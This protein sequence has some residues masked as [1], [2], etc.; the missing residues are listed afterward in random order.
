MIVFIDAEFTD[1]L[2]PQLLSLGAVTLDG[3][4]HYIELD[5][6]SD[7]GQERLEVSSDFVRND[8][9]L[10][11]FGL[12][13]DASCTYGDMG[14]RTGEWLLQLASE[15]GTRVE[16]AFDYSTDYQLMAHAIR[17]CGLWEQ[18][19][20]VVRP[21]DIGPFTASPEGQDAADKCFRAM[22]ARG[23]FR[24]HALADAHAP[25]CRL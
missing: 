23:L 7:I 19:R 21:I 18:V 17:D 3:R 8:G 14:R 11:L 20:Q 15:S 4:E 5:M 13:P 6:S 12:V 10:D 1:L 24:H 16:V 9:V 22:S 2:D 25:E